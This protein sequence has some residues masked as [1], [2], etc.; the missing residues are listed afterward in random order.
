MKSVNY[1]FNLLSTHPDF[2]FIKREY[3]FIQTY[4]YY[5]CGFLKSRP[6]LVKR[7]NIYQ[8]TIKNCNVLKK[9]SQNKLYLTP[10]KK[11][12]SNEK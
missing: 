11:F 6:L 1:P 5:D 2:A 7:T 9:I 12:N 4:I 8:L 10:G 3:N